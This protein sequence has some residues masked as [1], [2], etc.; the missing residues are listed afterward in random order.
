M[1]T[2]SAVSKDLFQSLTLSKSEKAFHPW[3]DTLENF[4]LYGMITTAIMVLQ[5]D[6]MKGTSMDCTFCQKDYCES[7][8]LTYNNSQADPGF[9]GKW[10][11]QQCSSPALDPVRYYPYILMAQA[12]VLLVCKRGTPRLFTSGKKMSKFYEFVTAVLEEDTDQDFDVDAIHVKDLFRN[13]CDYYYGYLFQTVSLLTLTSCFIFNLHRHYGNHWRILHN[14]DHFICT[15]H[16][17]YYYECHGMPLIIYL[18]LFYLASTILILLI[19]LQIYNILWMVWSCFPHLSKLSRE[20]RNYQENFRENLSEEQKNKFTKEARRELLGD[21]Y[22]IY[23][24]SADLA[25][26]LNLLTSS[27]GIADS[28]V[29]MTAL[30]KVQ[31]VPPVLIKYISKMI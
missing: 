6:V 9:D 22:D 25:L 30:D 3:W 29:I 17:N 10:V 1:A 21:L 2:I 20:M 16:V 7:N 24:S 15:L 27:S 23:Y 4:I 11:R 5:T 31:L 18:Y 14:A 12:I 8:G 13:S 28:L 26:F 19:I